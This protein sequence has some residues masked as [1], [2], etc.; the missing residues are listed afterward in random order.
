MSYVNNISIKIFSL[1]PSFCSLGCVF[2]ALDLRFQLLAGCLPPDVPLHMSHHSVAPPDMSVWFPASPSSSEAHVQRWTCEDPP[3]KRFP[4]HFSPSSWP[5]AARALPVSLLWTSGVLFKYTALPG[6]FLKRESDY[7]RDSMY[8]AVIICRAPFWV[9]YKYLLV[10]I[11]LTIV[12]GLYDHNYISLARRCHRF[13]M[14]LIFVALRN[15]MTQCFV[16]T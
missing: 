15:I 1:S 7:L 6:I 13:K 12:W 10:F 9:L 3:P 8:V 5:W 16:I 4:A 2:W 11:L 14:Y